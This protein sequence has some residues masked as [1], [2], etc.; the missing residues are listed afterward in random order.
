MYYTAKF[1]VHPPPSR[2]S[3]CRTRK[4]PAL[5][6]HP[7]WVSR[8]GHR[9]RSSSAPSSSSP[10]SYPWCRFWTLL[11]C[12]EGSGGGGAAEA[13]RAG[14]RAGHRS[15]L[16]LFGPGPPA[17][18]HSTSAGGRTV[19]GSADGA[20]IFTGGHCRAG[21]GAEGSG[22]GG[23]DRV[24]SS[25]SGSARGWR[26]VFK[27]NEQDTVQQ[28]RTWSRS[29]TFQLAVEAFKVF[30]QARVPL[31]PHRVVCMT[32]QMREFKGFF[33]IFPQPKKSAKVTRQ[34]VRT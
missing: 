1:W 5:P 9:R 7:V 33:R 15:A 12:W 16:D 13:R 2:S 31:L 26:E 34:A 19:G 32:T 22:T 18:C 23:A 17:F 8:G 28:R 3:S 25:S 10:T 27:V 29:L 24:K 4:S 14:C 11:G 30:T 21:P 20:G 6:G